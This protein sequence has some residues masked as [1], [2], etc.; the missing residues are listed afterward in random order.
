VFLNE[1]QAALKDYVAEWGFDWHFA[2]ETLQKIVAPH[3]TK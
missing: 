2:I 1:D 3:L